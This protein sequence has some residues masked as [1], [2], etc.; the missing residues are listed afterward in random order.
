M[1]RLI[2]GQTFEIYANH[3]TKGGIFQHTFGLEFVF[4]F[5]TFFWSYADLRRAFHI[6]VINQNTVFLSVKVG[7]E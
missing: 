1:K 4:W 5:I 2:I 7:S 3:R 6:V